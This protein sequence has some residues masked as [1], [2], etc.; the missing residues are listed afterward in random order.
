MNLLQLI[1]KENRDLLG[2]T[3]EEL[4]SD[5][6]FH[7]SMKIWQILLQ[8]LK[9]EMSDTINQID[10][11]ESQI[12]VEFKNIKDY[13]PMVFLNYVHKSQVWVSEYIEFLEVDEV[14]ATYHN[15]FQ[16]IEMYLDMINNQEPL[17]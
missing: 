16:Q 4:D 3:K 14:F 1:E 15:Q 10:I 13:Y 8:T 5:F 12:V 17:S 2:I 6:V 7:E 11:M 9:D